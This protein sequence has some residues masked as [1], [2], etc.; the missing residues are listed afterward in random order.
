[1][2]SITTHV[3]R[4]AYIYNPTFKDNRYNI[5]VGKFAN[6]APP[7]NMQGEALNSVDFP[8][9]REESYKMTTLSHS[10]SRAECL[11]WC[12]E[13]VSFY[14]FLKDP[15]IIWFFG[16]KQQRTVR[17][18]DHYYLSYGKIYFLSRYLLIN[19]YIPGVRN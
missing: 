11:T 1:M 7:P 6:D 12:Y 4:A 2:P 14:C 8:R 13:K 3:N 9:I 15:T 16:Q 17:T 18:F 10:V 19:A 5:R